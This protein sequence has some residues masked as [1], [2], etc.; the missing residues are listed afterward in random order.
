[1]L[2]L[3]SQQ[4]DE[5]AATAGVAPLVVVPGQDFYAAIADNLGVFGIDDGG[6]RI[7]LEVGGDEFLLGVAEDALHRTAGSGFQC[8]VDEFLGSGLVDKDGEVDDADVG[9]RH[10][11]GVTVELALQFRDDKVQRFGGSSRAGNHVE[12]GGASAAQVLVRKIEELLI[13]GVRMDGGHGAAVDPEGVMKHSGDGSEAVGGARS[14]GNDVM[15]CG[16]VGLV[17]DAEDKGGVG[18]IGGCGYNYF[19]YGRAKMLLRVNAFGEKASGF[20]HDIGPDGRPIDF[21]WIL[22]LENLETPPFHGD[23]LIGMRH[24]V[25]Q[26]AEDGVVFQEVR[27]SFGVGDVVDGHEL[28]ILVV[29]RGAHD[30]ATDAA[31]TVDANLD[32]HYFLR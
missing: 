21:R 27:E 16:I 2:K 29:E 20:D 15:R 5:V 32:G 24:V 19:F 3:R 25:G 26:I 8:G 22:G 11:H 7:A 14:V 31:E 23:G 1:M 13:V 10:T 17:V 12:C 18:T 6:I 9:R 4:F 28:N 30:V